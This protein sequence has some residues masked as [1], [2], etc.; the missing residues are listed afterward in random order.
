MRN[1]FQNM[2]DS[3]SVEKSFNFYSK[4]FQSLLFSSPM[5]I[6]LLR[7]KIQELKNTFSDHTIDHQIIL[8]FSLNYEK[9]PIVSLLIQI[10]R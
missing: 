5:N 3:N 10:Q 8:A 6:Q 1:M 2:Q 7:T 9:I 4:I